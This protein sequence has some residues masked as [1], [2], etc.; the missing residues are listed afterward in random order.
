[1]VA[2]DDALKGCLF[3]FNIFCAYFIFQNGGGGGQIYPTK[4]FGN[5]L[6]K[7][8]KKFI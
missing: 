5:F 6:N 4:K 3:T 2:L 1:M 8:K 7:L